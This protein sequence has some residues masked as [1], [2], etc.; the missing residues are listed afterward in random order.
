MCAEC[1]HL[2]QANNQ[3]VQ[4]IRDVSEAAIVFAR[5]LANRMHGEYQ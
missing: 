3:Q 1:C 5:E 2:V 4:C